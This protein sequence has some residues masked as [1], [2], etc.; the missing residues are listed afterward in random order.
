MRMREVVVEGTPALGSTEWLAAFLLSPGV[1]GLTAVLAAVLAL[2]AARA[3]IRADA[4]TARRVRAHART[5]AASARDAEVEDRDL[6][7]W[8]SVYRWTVD[9]ADR[10]GRDALA[11]VFAAL[12]DEAKGPVTAALAAIAWRGGPEHDEEPR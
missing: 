4:T 2:V 1:A 10:E 6:A 3:R 5:S 7:W 9:R 8:W 11:P 12:R